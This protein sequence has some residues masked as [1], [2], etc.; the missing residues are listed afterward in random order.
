MLAFFFVIVAVGCCG[1][2][3]LF[4]VAALGLQII[5]LYKDMLI[6]LQSLLLCWA[7]LSLSDSQFSFRLA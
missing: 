7:A 3:F 2:L 1:S 5:V 6:Y 4:A